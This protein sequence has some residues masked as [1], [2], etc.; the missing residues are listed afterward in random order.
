[1]KRHIR[2][3]LWVLLRWLDDPVADQIDPPVEV[4]HDLDKARLRISLVR[5]QVRAVDRKLEQREARHG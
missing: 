2:R 4:D 5:D 3:V 1:M